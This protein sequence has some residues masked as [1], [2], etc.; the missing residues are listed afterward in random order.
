MKEAQKNLEKSSE[1]VIEKEMNK[2]KQ[3][4]EE[5]VKILNEKKC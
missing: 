5:I 1:G 3:K 2:N 4:E